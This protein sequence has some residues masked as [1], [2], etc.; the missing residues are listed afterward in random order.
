[1]NNCRRYLYHFI[2][3]GICSA[4]TAPLFTQGAALREVSPIHSGLLMLQF[5]E[6]MI[7][8]HSAGQLND[9]DVIYR[10]PLDTA[11]AR[12]SARFAVSSP[13]DPAY[14]VARQPGAVGRKSKGDDFSARWPDYPVVLN[15]FIYLA[16]PA[17]LQEGKTYTVHWDST[18]LQTLQGHFTFVFQTGKMRSEA[19]H[20]NQVGYLAEPGLPKYGYVYHWAGDMGGVDFSSFRESAFH[21]VSEES[22]AAVYTGTLAFRGSGARQENSRTNE[23]QSY[24]RSD[25][26]ECDFSAFDTP[27]TY[28]LVVEGIGASFPFRIGHD[29]Y[30]EAFYHTARALYHQRAGLAKDNGS[31]E[32][33]F[34]RDHHPDDGFRVNLTTIRD[35]GPGF[36]GNLAAWTSPATGKK[37]GKWGWY[38]DAGDWDPYPRHVYVSNYLLTVYEL[39]PDR[40]SDGELNIPE[41]G[42]GI[43][44]II[45]EAAWVINYLKRTTAISPT[46]GV[47]ARSNYAPPPPRGIPSWADPQPWYATNEDPSSTFIFA[48]G[49]AQLAYNLDLAA[50]FTGNPAVAGSSASLMQSAR[51]AFDWAMSN[52]LP[53]DSTALQYRINRLMAAVWMY[54]Y[55]GEAF[56]QDKLRE[57]S[58]F[59]TASSWDYRW[60]E[61]IFGFATC[62]DH[63]GLDASLRQLYR[64]MTLNHAESWMR[65][66]AQNRNLR[67]AWDW[68]GPS[69][70]G[71]QTT[72]QTLP[73]IVAYALT[74]DETW[75]EIVLTSADFNLG[76]N[77]LNMVWVT[78]IGH[79]RPDKGILHL[80]SWYY[81]FESKNTGEV[82]PGIVPYAHHV[83]GMDFTGAANGPHNNDWAVQRLYPP[84]AA[85]PLHETWQNNRQSPRTGEFTI[86]QNIAKAAAVYGFLSAPGGAAFQPAPRPTIRFVSDHAGSSYAAG[87]QVRLS[88]QAASESVISRVEFFAAGLCIAIIYPNTSS[89]GIY[90]TD[91]TIFNGK[92]GAV[93][94]EAVAYDRRGNSATART[95]VMVQLLSNDREAI[96][97]TPSLRIY[98]NPVG[99]GQLQIE[100]SQHCPQGLLRV[101]TADGRLLETHHIAWPD[102]TGTLDISGQAPGLLIITIR[103]GEREWTGK[104]VVK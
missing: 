9:A 75:R 45:D 76:C 60:M 51:A 44:D 56:Y 96:N 68:N 43:P 78:G 37:V 104:V 38:H 32:W 47:L 100:L 4:W 54:K 89:E 7:A 67:M 8:Y 27:G 77:P 92:G 49:A 88:V 87:Q 69:F 73:A 57:W 103:C 22:G 29:V 10:Y 14:A 90:Q 39:F 80:D 23:P 99:A 55:T 6:G 25:V 26:W 13:D 40:F 52:S 2:L 74:G 70:V 71:L 81:E 86:N 35:L 101:T 12:Q 50:E 83:P 102:G 79:R 19:I 98:P 63:P 5:D 97:P 33:A 15:H 41:S 16:L 36:E 1:M 93:P 21:L 95:A 84:A 48:A 58:P 94:I 30:R 91:W 72:P 53:S 34:P 59:T 46:G 64:D 18:A 20:V 3:F 62:P 28:R 61:P 65:E 17:R 66:S 11:Q 31:T 82:I 24:T 85:W 42:N